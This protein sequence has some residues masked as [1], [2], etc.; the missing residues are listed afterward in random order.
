MHGPK[1]VT[2]FQSTAKRRKVSFAT[3]L[4]LVIATVILPT[5]GFSGILLKRYAESEQKRAERVLVESTKALAKAIDAQFITAEAALLALSDS[6]L[7]DAASLGEFE[8]RLR[9]TTESTGRY[10]LLADSTGQQLINTYFSPERPLPRNESGLWAPIFEKREPYVTNVI[11]GLSSRQLLTGIGVPVVRDN[12]VKWVLAAGLFAENFKNLVAEPGVPEDWIVSIV[13]RTGTHIIRSHANDQFAG[14]PL[15]P[16]LIERMRKG[17]TGT[18]RSTSLE[19]IPLI[20]TIQYAPRSGWAAAMGIPVAALEAPMRESIRDLLALGAVLAVVAL[21]MG[22]LVSRLLNRTVSNLTTMAAALGRGEPIS[23][24]TSMIVEADTIS[25]V[26]A[27]ASRDLKMLTTNL[28]TQVDQRTEDL[29]LA[30]ANLISEIERRQ[31]SEAQLIQVQ[32]VEA[33]GQLTGGIAHD[34]NNML[35]IILGSLRLLQRR[36]E[37]GDTDVQKYIDGAVQGA[38]RAANLT[39]RLL[40][41]SRQQPLAPEIVDVNKLLAGM[42]EIL[43]RT[44][45][46]NVQI[47]T[48]LAD[49]VGRGFA[50]TQGLESTIINLATNARDAMRN[51]GKLIIETGNIYLDEA[52]T[53]THA[54]VK[55]GPYILIAVTDSGEGMPPDVVD[56]A[57]DPFF[58]TKQTG[59]GTGLGL[60]QVHGFMKQSGGHVAIYSERSR[61]TTVKLFLPQYL[62]SVGTGDRSKRKTQSCPRARNGETILV[63]EDETGVRQLTVEML[64]ELGYATVEAAGANDALEKLESHPEITLLL[65]DVIMPGAN[66][67]QLAN[68]ALKRRPG[69][70]VLFATGYTRNAIVDHGILDPDVHVLMKPFMLETLA[71]KVSELLER[72]SS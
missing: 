50:D 25:H 12:E 66:G 6:P 13:D 8:L 48:M 20:T 28:E 51:G 38:E 43:R 3:I 60:S 7:L 62:G 53:A 15:A 24:G 67:R 2:D 40:A 69:L 57:F 19:G 23:A 22:L 39:S 16:E 47:E 30:N 42:G 36:L 21:G 64:Q 34:F 32:K 46:E 55:V 68:E 45:P 37:R 65:T 44:I 71:Q 18:L 27:Q 63:V 52:Y 59:S 1:L 72:G 56:R 61:G 49:D 54:E 4:V 17:H 41:F 70:A 26:L 29:S 35:A 33:I 58:T 10:F 31:Q 11:R 9:R 5:L 14:K